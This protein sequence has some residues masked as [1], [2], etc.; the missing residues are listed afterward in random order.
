MSEKIVEAISE[1][2][3]DEVAG[4]LNV[5]SSKL[6]K[7]LI[8]AGVTVLVG[9]AGIVFAGSKGI[10]PLKTIFYDEEYGAR[11]FKKEFDPEEH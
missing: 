5:N 7:V 1:E 9:G 2:T 3:I 6:K 8:G 4:G 11:K 10:G